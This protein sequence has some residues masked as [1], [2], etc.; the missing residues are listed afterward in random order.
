[1]FIFSAHFDFLGVRFNTLSNEIRH[2][3]HIFSR[4][5]TLSLP[6]QNREIVE[7]EAGRDNLNYLTNINLGGQTNKQSNPIPAGRHK[8]SVIGLPRRIFLSVLEDALR[9]F[10]ETCGNLGDVQGPVP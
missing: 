1:M 4:F 2:K 8:M 7:Q 9:L 5:V 6:L 10:G 3:I